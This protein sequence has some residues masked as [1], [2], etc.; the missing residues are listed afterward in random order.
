[1]RVGFSRCAGAAHAPGAQHLLDGG[2]QAV[3]ILQHDLVEFLALGLVHRARLQ[4]FQIEPD[5]RHRSLQLVGDG[6][7]EGVVLFVAADFAHQKD[8]I[9]HDAAA[10]HQHQQDAQDQQDAVPPVQQDIADVENQQDG[11]QPD[12]ERDMPG[13]RSAASG[14]FHDS[15]LARP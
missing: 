9:Q 4:R 13:N 5:G 11:D 8:R 6:I 2:Q 10:D 15:R 7:D 14:E 3:A 1:M 12:A